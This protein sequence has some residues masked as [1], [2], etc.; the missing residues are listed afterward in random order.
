MEVKSKRLAVHNRKRQLISK[1]YVIKTYDV[2][3]F[4]GTINAASPSNV[5]VRRYTRISILM[6]MTL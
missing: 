3:G 5:K 4:D 6:L 1:Q 2:Y